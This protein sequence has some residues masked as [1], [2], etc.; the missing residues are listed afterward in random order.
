MYNR[1]MDTAKWV[2]SGTTYLLLNGKNTVHMSLTKLKESAKVCIC[3]SSVL[4]VW[5]FFYQ[6]L[7]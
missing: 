5:N 1:E 7:K 6:I 4:V 2:S 3:V